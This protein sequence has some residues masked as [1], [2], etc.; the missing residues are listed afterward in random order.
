MNTQTQTKLFPQFRFDPKFTKF[1]AI[2]T[3]MWLHKKMMS[4]R[5]ANH[6]LPQLV[7]R[8]LA[9]QTM[10]SRSTRPP[11]TYALG[12]TKKKLLASYPIINLTKAA[13]EVGASNAAFQA[14]N[15]RLIK[16]GHVAVQKIPVVSGR[17]NSRLYTL[18]ASGERLKAKFLMAKEAKQ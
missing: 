9:G 12:K 4:V 7:G 3:E 15:L 14:A 18:T 5:P 11:S 8:P 6:L 17:G 13:A 1:R 16:S 2:K 10:I